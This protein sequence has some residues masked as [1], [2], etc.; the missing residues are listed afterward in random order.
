MTINMCDW[1]I[2]SNFTLLGPDE[3]YSI[4][5]I[6]TKIKMFYIIPF[7]TRLVVELF[8]LFIVRAI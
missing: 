1:S 7:K 5:G 6:I 3:T 8:T 2:N 4:Y